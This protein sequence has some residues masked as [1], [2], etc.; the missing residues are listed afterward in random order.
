MV[1]W[2]VWSAVGFITL[3]PSHYFFSCWLCF[4]PS[5]N[6]NLL[7]STSSLNNVN[8]F[9]IQSFVREIR[10]T[11]FDPNHMSAQLF[12]YFFLA[13][14]IVSLPLPLISLANVTYHRRW[15]SPPHMITRFL[16]WSSYNPR[17]PLPSH[18]LPIFNKN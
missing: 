4:L 14:Q 5:W 16:Q 2:N 8:S 1:P 11:A 17:L 18:F 9:E 15:F 3:F 7:Q 10:S 12:L 13:K 6:V